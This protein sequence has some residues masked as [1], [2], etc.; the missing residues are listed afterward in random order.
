LAAGENKKLAKT[1]FRGVKKI[2]EN[3]IA[4][5]RALIFTDEDIDNYDW[6]DI[7]DGSLL[8]NSNS[9]EIKVKLKGQTSWLPFGTKNDGT[10]SIA[11][12]SIIEHEVFTVITLDDGND[13]DGNPLNT[14]TYEDEN[15]ELRHGQ[16]TQE[17]YY[18]FELTKGSYNMYR[19][20]LKVTIDDC[21]HR[22]VAT[23]GVIEINEKRFALTEDLVEN[24]EIS[25][26]YVRLFR[27]G[28]PYP[29]VFINTDEPD[30]SE[31]G[32]LWID[33]DGSLADNDALGENIE[34]STTIS[35][36]RITGKPTTVRGYGITDNLTY[37][38]HTHTTI[39]I[40]DFPTSL[41]ANGGNAD[42]V[43]GYH[44]GNKA[45]TVLI[46]GAN[47]TIP[48]NNLC[49]HKHSQS[50]ITDLQ[51]FT[52]GMIIDWYGSSDNVPSGWHICDGTYGTPDL[53]DRFVVG[54]G[55]SYALGSTGG[56]ATHTLTV[57]EM[58]SHNHT[59]D[60][61]YSNE[62]GVSGDP[63]GSGNVSRREG[64]YTFVSGS[65]G[66]NGAHNNLPPYMA[67]FKIMK[68]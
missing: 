14:F 61:V 39:D 37:V 68:L 41:P 56:E 24:M 38:G 17:G 21:L 60:I 64:T 52:R 50:D 48:L 46:I 30:D 1:N 35:W 2:N 59:T 4:N 42:T 9:G 22:S 11:K 54:A 10:I 6:N 15:N 44:A 29:R 47:G 33:T 28:N 67:L 26:E 34:V 65:T 7:P 16:K 5:G 31:V 32:D 18:V 12:D 62:D 45:G 40:L 58:P 25:V 63:W 49:S 43:D 57:S 27:I 19:N 53:R 55:K 66:G 13:N 20:Y 51:V 3:I 8:V 36:D 23:G